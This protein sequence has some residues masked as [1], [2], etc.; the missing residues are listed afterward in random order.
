MA[1]LPGSIP[2]LVP[3]GEDETQRRLRDVE[4]RLDEL[5]PS[6]ARSFKPVLD[7]LIVAEVK[8]DMPPYGYVL[9]TTNTVI[10]TITFTVPAGYTRAV[11]T[12]N[13]QLSGTNGSSVSA[14]ITVWPS[15]NSGTISQLYQGIGPSA[16][17][18]AIAVTTYSL[19]D[20]MTGLVEG[21]P[22][23]FVTEAFANVA[24]AFGSDTHGSI[25]VMVLWMR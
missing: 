21:Q 18:S 14:Y 16:A 13:S 10:S 24:S 25:E 22:L 6:V 9:T 12:Y 8:G 23:T 3:P 11:F 4:R 7:A 1:G 19:S 15:A 5:G 20:V 2:S 17:P